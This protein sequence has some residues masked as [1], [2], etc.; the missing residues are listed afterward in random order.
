[1]VADDPANKIRLKAF[2]CTILSNQVSSSSTSL[3]LEELPEIIRVNTADLMANYHK[4]K[5]DCLNLIDMIMS[6]VT[7]K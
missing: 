3:Y 4:I 2:H 5:A 7:S 1:M 6:S